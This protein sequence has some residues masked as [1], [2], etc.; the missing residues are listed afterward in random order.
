MLL[1]HDPGQA[2]RG[3]FDDLVAGEGLAVHDPTEEGFEVHG[4]GRG[5]VGQVARRGVS[6]G[7]AGGGGS[8]AGGGGGAFAAEISA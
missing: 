2:D 7:S 5:V 8:A 3:V 4:P 6:S 1:S